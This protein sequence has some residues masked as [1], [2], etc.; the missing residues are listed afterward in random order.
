MY[1]IYKTQNKI[2][3]KP[4]KMTLDYTNC[5]NKLYKITKGKMHNKN[6]LCYCILHKIGII[7]NLKAFKIMHFALKNI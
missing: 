4:Y 2:N 3:K 6:K 5:T 1:N 7:T